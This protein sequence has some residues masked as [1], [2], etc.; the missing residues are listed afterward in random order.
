MK[1]GSFAAAMLA[2][3]ALPALAE[4][5][6]QVYRD[7]QRYDAQYSSARYALDAGREKLPQGRAL[8]LPTLG[9]TGNYTRQ[10]ID[11]VTHDPSLSPSF[12]RYPRAFGYQLTF[13]QPV[14]RPQNWLQYD[15]GE[16]QVKQAE[17][18]FGQ[19]GQDLMLRVAQAYFD[20]LAAEDTLEVVR[21]QKSAISEQLAQAKR[22]FEVGTAT[23]TDTH[24]AQ[25]RSD[26]IQAQEIAAQNDLDNRRR[27]LQLITG[28]EYAQ[29]Q[30]LRPDV[31]LS[32]PNPNDM[33]SWVDL[34]EK[35]SYPVLIQQA[36]TDIARLEAKRNRAAHWPTLDLVGTHGT[37]NQTGTLTSGVGND[38]TVTTFGLQLALPLY[39]GGALDSRE[40]EAAA[41][42]L[43]GKDDLE[44]ARRAAALTARQNYLSVINGIAQVGA[45]EQALVS[46]QS[47]LESNKLGY[48]VGVRINID[49]LNAQQQL[50]STQRDLAVARYNTITN[51]LRLKSAAGS[52][53]EQDLEEVNRAL[54]P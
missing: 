35:Q 30:H 32:Q 40:R 53:V 20:V 14:F 33:Q 1:K 41:L 12:L 42:A 10:R 3:A 45:L 54:Q 16:V 22:N 19:A 47:A 13:T 17:A 52:L 25:A 15:E 24:E 28:K 39:Q 48:E 50:Y 8:V 51:H 11:S 27:A 23:I 37:T 5:L 7:A 46:S 6:M 18:S 34:A 44:N 9:V 2:C 29:L 38:L 31:K 49:V 36:T 43:K 21:T 4:D 26:L